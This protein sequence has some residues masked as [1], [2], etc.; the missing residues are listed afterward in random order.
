P[1]PQ[2][3]QGQPGQSR[4]QSFTNVPP[5]ANGIHIDT[6]ALTV[7]DTGKLDS[8]HR[9]VTPVLQPRDTVTAEA[10]AA[11]PEKER[12]KWLPEWLF[13]M[14]L[15]Q[16]ALIVFVRV[17]Y[18]REFN[19]VFTVFVNNAL[20]QQLYRETQV[21][22]MRMGYFLLNFNFIISLGTWAYLVFKFIGPGVG[23]PDIYILPFAVGLVGVLLVTRFAALR[24]ATWLL[25]SSKEIGLFNFTDL[26]LFRA[27][28]LLLFPVNAFLA[29]APHQQRVYF[30]WFSM[31]VL[32]TF[33][34]FRALRGFEI[35]RTRLS[36]NVFHFLVYICA[37]EIA[38]VLVGIRLFLNTFGL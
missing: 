5:V 16:M 31:V 2:T 24:T 13:W 6:N 11:M 22:G 20:T 4:T 19:E 8:L 34:L 38:P 7:A 27:T 25:K 30:L 18:Y 35:G 23:H 3:E 12:K 1:L 26:Q 37:L 32:V 15:V 33:I 9:A 10:R 17:Q 28:G 36:A 14:M 29:Y 21:G